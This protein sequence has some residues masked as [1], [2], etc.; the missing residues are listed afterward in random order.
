MPFSYHAPASQVV[1]SSSAEYA[2]SKLDELMKWA[3]TGSMWP[4]TFGLACCAIEM[5]HASAG[6]AQG[7]KS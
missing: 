6:A 4:M 3:R 5:M 1:P 7:L 2:V